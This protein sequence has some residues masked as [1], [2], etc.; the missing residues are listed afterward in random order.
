MQMTAKE[1]LVRADTLR[2]AKALVDKQV[3]WAL[4]TM[5]SYP[6]DKFG[7]YMQASFDSQAKALQMMSQIISYRIE[8]AEADAVYLQSLENIVG[9]NK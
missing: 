3:E 7:P 6:A 1:A 5:K 8:S 2:E 4:N 9:G